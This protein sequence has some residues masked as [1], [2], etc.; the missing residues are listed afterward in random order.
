MIN[1]VAGCLGLL[2]AVSLSC[3]LLD[4]AAPLPRQ[5]SRHVYHDF[6]DE[7][8]SLRAALPPP[9]AAAARRCC[10]PCASRPVLLPSP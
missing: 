8:T 1:R 6:A 7:H 4:E 5:L 3:H 9:R 2:G 10:S